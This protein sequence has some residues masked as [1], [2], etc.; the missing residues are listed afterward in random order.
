MPARRR[1]DLFGDD[2]Q[3]LAELV[4]LLGELGV[5]PQ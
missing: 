3:A 1:V 2:A 5:L 4:D